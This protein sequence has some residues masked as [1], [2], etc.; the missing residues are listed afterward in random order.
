MPSGPYLPDSAS[1]KI[2][3]L[4]PPTE[5]SLEAQ[6]D[7]HHDDLV[8]S[9]LT[10]HYLNTFHLMFRSP[11]TLTMSLVPLLFEMSVWNA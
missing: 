6:V 11:A 8:I 1:L 3:V 10:S 7:F 2:D 9:Q 4:E 5:E